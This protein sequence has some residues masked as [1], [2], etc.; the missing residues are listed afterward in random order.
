[1]KYIAVID[2]TDAGGFEIGMA[3]IQMGYQPLYLLNPQ[4]YKAD[5]ALSLQNFEIKNVDTQSISEVIKI[6]EPLKNHIF[7]ITTLVDSRIPIAASVALHF[8]IPG[9]DSACILLKD[10]AEV[11]KMCSE[12][13]LKTLALNNNICTKKYIRDYFGEVALI[14]KKRLGCGAVGFQILNNSEEIN[15][16]IMNTSKLNEWI[17]QEYFQGNL[18]S[19]EGWSEDENI[20]FLGWTSRRKIANTESE[21]RFEGFSTISKE[22]TELA[23]KSI[24]TLFKKSQFKRGWFHI[25]FLINKE[26][27]KLM[28]IDANIGRVGGAMLPHVLAMSFSILPA[29]LY[30]HALEV[31]MLGKSAIKIE[32]QQDL[33]RIYKCIC[34]GAPRETIIEQVIL[35]QYTTQSHYL[36]FIRILDHGDHVSK[37]G[38]DD[39]SWIGFVAGEENAV[40]QYASQILLRSQDGIVE[41][42]VY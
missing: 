25:E 7:G 3:I 31:Q 30:Q 39:W 20:S 34:F 23:K 4:N 28:M 27:N 6:L 8:N 1:M 38:H 9:P 21:F 32:T 37:M 5:L 19:M 36:R 12:F 15:C 41:N 42:V 22:L 16:F 2:S 13:S 11:A 29:T 40:E 18:Y 10:K 17:F 26:Q 35:P 24:V 14:A 33:S